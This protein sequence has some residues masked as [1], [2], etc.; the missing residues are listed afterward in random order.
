M[1]LGGFSSKNPAA[2]FTFPSTPPPPRTREEWERVLIGVKHLYLQRQYKQ[3]A[4]RAAE[5]SNSA[6][7]PIHPIYQ[8]FL[9]FYSAISYEFLG[10]AA[11]P[12]SSNKVSF[13]YLALDHFLDC[14]AALPAPIPLPKLPSGYESPTATPSPVSPQTPGSSLV[15]FDT[16][17]RRLPIS[18]E[19]V[20]SI[21][22][23]IDV[24]LGT[25][26]DPFI[27]DHETENRTPFMI[28]L[29]QPVHHPR[30]P[31]KENPLF[32]VMISPDKACKDTRDPVKK[33]PLMPS[34]LRIHKSS[35]DSSSCAMKTPER[36]E[37]SKEAMARPRPPPL[38]LQVIP[39]SRL[40]I[41]RPV[42][43]LTEAISPRRA[44]Q[45]VRFNRGVGFL[46]SQVAT[47]ITEIQ[48]HADHIT[49]IQRSRRARKIQRVASFWS[50]SP[51]KSTQNTEI[52]HEHDPVVDQ[53][54]NILVSETKEQRI[55][56]LRSEGWNTVGLRSPRSTWKG[57]RYY[58][59]FCSMVLNELDLD[60]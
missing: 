27:S 10:Q 8:V 13:L 15:A 7:K 51:I 4:L 48:E 30:S 17:Q 44:A 33:D 21:S 23:M 37:T 19:L 12:Y 20:H 60:Q 3:C 29:T 35:G 43:G 32:R 22:R 40:N 54:G 50:F 38:P 31:I 58:Q 46:Q 28:S 26:D 11:H 9:S 42:D 16:V 55:A 45:I 41:N 34:P 14:S 47:N 59:E 25:D 39:T 5:I 52:K 53:F 56:R 49:E 1:M 18:E 6:R 36:K 24:S 2:S 57:A